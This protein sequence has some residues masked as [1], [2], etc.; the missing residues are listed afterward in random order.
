[1]R[2]VFEWNRNKARSNVAKHRVS[3]EEARTIFLDRL[4]LTQ[5]DE[6]HFDEEDRLISIGVSSA[7]RLLTVV[8]F[9]TYEAPD[10]QIVR[11]ISAR[12]VTTTEL[13]KYEKQEE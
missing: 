13:T 11:I 5:R 12:K 10:T 6:E 4:T 2:I 9:E 7:G 1:M 3:F 8:H